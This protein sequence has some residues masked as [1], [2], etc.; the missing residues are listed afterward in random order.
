MKYQAYPAYKDSGVEWLGKIPEGWE[1][2]KV[3]H[4]FTTCS[5]TTPPAGEE[6]WYG[7]NIPWITTGELRESDISETEKCITVEALN[8]FTALKIIPENSLL[9]AMYGATIGRLARNKVPATM[10]QAC[11]ALAPKMTT[12]TEYAFFYFQ[13]AKDFLILLSSGGGQPNISQEKIR[14][15]SIPLPPLPTQQAIAAFLDAETARIDGL[16]KDYE[17][18]VALL[19]EKRQALISHAVTRGLSELASPDD[20]DFGR[21]AAQNCARPVKFKDSGVEWLGEIP[22]GW[23]VP[24]LGYHY[25]VQLGKM[26]DAAQIAGS[27]LF[28]YLRNQDVQWGNINLEE[29]P[30]MDFSISEQ[31][32][33][34]LRQGDLLVCEGGDVGRAAVWK[35]NKIPCFYQKALHRIRPLDCTGSDPR[36]LLYVLMMAN[37][38]G[39]FVGGEDK[40]TIYHLTADRLRKFRIPLPKMEEQ[41]TIAAFLDRETAK[42]DELV[43]EAESAIELLKE[44]RSA[45]IT[46]AVTGKINVEGLA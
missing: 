46:N 29:L 41:T 2:W 39:I 18:L 1:V 19:R 28:P 10:N 24:A 30:E 45:L 44:R 38:N 20:P 40:S 8:H 17:E 37:K 7:G 4:A 5:G 12:T 14:G 6:K 15:F 3:S 11:C 35:H 16:V 34:S 22:E 25:E 13:V 9:I 42:M 43:A 31:Q 23:A 36:Y 27:Q 32:K 21:W 26:L 33:F